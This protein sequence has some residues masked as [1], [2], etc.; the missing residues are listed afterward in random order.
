MKGAVQCRST[1]IF[2]RQE[3]GRLPNCATWLN[4]AR[5]LA[6]GIVGKEDARRLLDFA[7][8]LEG[9]AEALEILGVR[10]P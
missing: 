1:E 4:L 9:R 8:E 5:R 10:Y 3:C 7:K 6:M 2:R